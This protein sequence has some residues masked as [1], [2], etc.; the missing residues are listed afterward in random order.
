MHNL[1]DATGAI[2]AT[3]D[4]PWS[5]DAAGQGWRAGQHLVMDPE[6]VYAALPAP[7]PT[8]TATEFIDLFLPTEEAAIS[9]S[10]DPVV[11]AFYGRIYDQ[12]RKDVRLDAPLVIAGVGH[13]QSAGLLTAER[14]AAILAGQPPA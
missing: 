4:D 13:C 10:A 1:T 7:P 9:A 14:A 12:R 3:A 5:W 2:I 6:R 8:L 11:K